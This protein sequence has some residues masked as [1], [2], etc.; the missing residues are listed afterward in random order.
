MSARLGVILSVV[1]ATA[2]VPVATPAQS[3]VVPASPP[4]QSTAPEHS[5]LAE[6]TRVRV[7]APPRAGS[8]IG[9]VVAHSADSLILRIDADGRSIAL[10]TAEVTQVDLS[11]G[12][13]RN[14]LKGAGAGAIAGINVGAVL[15]YVTYEE[16]RC[17][18]DSFFC[19]D[20]RPETA[21]MGGA[22]VIGAL[23]TV[24]GFLAGM[25]STEEWTPAS[26][27]VLAPRMGIRP[28]SGG[29]VALTASLAF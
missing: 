2:V 10:P 17:A 13:R 27:G 28:A 19:I 16:V 22:A 26:R 8:F 20:L 7:L 29:G 5:R 11:A 3:T 21:A 23:G 25:R 9:A 1:V 12:S 15:G 6:G 4:A 18:P 14:I 24:A